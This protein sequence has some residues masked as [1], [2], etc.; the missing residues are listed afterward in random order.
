MKHTQMS[1][2][3][4]HINTIFEHKYRM[5]S[6]KVVHDILNECFT[7]LSN[8]MVSLFNKLQIKLIYRT[9]IPGINFP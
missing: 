3:F 5:F 2:P 7:V 9:R 4:A 8:K 1:V 6:P